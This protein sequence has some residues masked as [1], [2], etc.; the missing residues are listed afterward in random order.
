MKLVPREGLEPSRT[1]GLNVV[2]VPI[3]MCHL[4]IKFY[5]LIGREVCGGVTSG[6]GSTGFGAVS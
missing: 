4:G 5:V 6:S 1:Y 2:A 3:R